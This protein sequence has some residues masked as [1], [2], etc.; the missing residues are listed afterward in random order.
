[1]PSLLGGPSSPPAQMHK[2][3]KALFL[4]TAVGVVFRSEIAILVG[5]HAVWL[6]LQHRL[7][8]RGVI[9]PGLLGL[10]IGLCITVPVDSF[11]W[12]KF[13]T[14]PE[15]TGFVYNVM[16]GKSVAWGR[17]PFLYY[18][19]SA[20]PRLFLNPLTYLICIPMALNSPA[21]EGPALDMLIPNLAFIAIYSFQ[22]HKEWRFIVYA[23]PPL[24]AVAAMGA[25]WI[26]T[27]RAKNLAYRLLAMGLVASTAA[28]FVA[29]LG[30][31]LVSSYNYPGAQALIYLHDSAEGSKPDIRVHM[32][33]LSCMTGVTRFL[34]IPRATNRGTRWLYDKTEDEERLLHPAFWNQFDY[35][36]AERPE[37]AIGSWEVIHT[38][39][40]FAGFN[41][42]RPGQGLRHSRNAMVAMRRL[43]NS[44]KRSWE[45]VVDCLLELWMA[46]EQLM[47]TWVTRGWWLEARMEPR[48][49]ILKST[50]EW[51]IPE[52]EVDQGESR[53]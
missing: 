35:A 18:I 16:K 7:P 8:V 34:Q 31:A 24:T 11:F 52:K 21:L 47:R 1:M 2:L 17:S 25:S 9:V 38:V 39:Q 49:R 27:R 30:M 42:I 37:K 32:D 33:T 45:N 13:P 28:S 41:T 10:I 5:T 40:G 48:I 53:F 19:V 3:K 12:Q 51:I 6:L 22:P 20:I 43:V 29:S 44:E 46:F 15:F 50:K 26:W 14:W 4:L 23:I 36:L